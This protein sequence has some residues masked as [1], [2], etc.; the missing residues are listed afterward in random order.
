MNVPRK[1][2]TDRIFAVFNSVVLPASLNGGSWK[3]STKDVEI[4]TNVNAFDQPYLGL[5]VPDD[6]ASDNQAF[7]L[8]KWTRRYY[9]MIYFR[10]DAI[11][12]E[13]GTYV[14]DIIDD[15]IDAVDAAFAAPRKG[16]PNTLGGIVQTCMIDGT[17]FTDSGTLDQQC[18]II[19]PITIITGI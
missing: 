12:L 1:L 5:V 19:V 7:G 16:E 6:M 15:L 2:I 18:A 10:R 9:G 4:W 17:I 11:P 14:Q 8:T 3:T 13:P